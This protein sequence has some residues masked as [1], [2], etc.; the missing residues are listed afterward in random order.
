VTIGDDVFIGAGAVIMPGCHIGEGVVIG[1]NTVVN[2]DFPPYVNRRGYPGEN[3]WRAKVKHNRWFVPSPQPK[4]EDNEC[5]SRANLTS[6]S[7]GLI[8]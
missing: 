8:V 6:N 5:W 7:G 4:Q 2:K 1:A 3:N